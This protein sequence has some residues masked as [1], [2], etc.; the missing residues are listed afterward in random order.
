MIRCR[1][2]SAAAKC[3]ADIFVIE[4]R[5]ESSI[6]PRVNSPPWMCARGMLAIRAVAAAPRIS[7]RSPSRTI[8]SGLRVAMAVANPSMAIARE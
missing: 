4:W 3:M 7:N 2:S 8:I 6:A 5:T 1:Y